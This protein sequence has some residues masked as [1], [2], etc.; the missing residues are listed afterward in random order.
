MKPKRPYLICDSEPS[1]HFSSTKLIFLILSIPVERESSAK[2]FS[3]EKTDIAPKLKADAD[4]MPGSEKEGEEVP[5]D[6]Q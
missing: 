3:W 1:T 5:L 4:G 6:G 2:V